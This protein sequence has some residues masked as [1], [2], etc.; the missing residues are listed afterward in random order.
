[1]LNNAVE[2]KKPM[3]EALLR[4]RRDLGLDLSR[5]SVAN[6]D[7]TYL[8]LAVCNGKSYVAC[9]ASSKRK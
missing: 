7:V 1:M 3:V 9:A 5:D 8:Q 2:E 4:P 6:G